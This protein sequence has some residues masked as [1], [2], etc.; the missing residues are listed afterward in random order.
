MN[1]LQPL[2]ANTL[3]ALWGMLRRPLVFVLA[4]LLSRCP[5]EQVIIGKVAKLGENPS[6]GR[7]ICTDESACSD[8]EVGEGLSVRRKAQ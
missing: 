2:D 5:C 3:S 7:G 4:S 8:I 1:T 6:F